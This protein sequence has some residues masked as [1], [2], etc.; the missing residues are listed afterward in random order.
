M[1]RLC[2]VTG[3]NGFIGSNV[4]RVLLE[5][6]YD[7]RALV[8]GDIDQENLSGLPVKIHEIDVLDAASVRAA[9]AG[10][11]HVVHAAAC[12]AFWSQDPQLPYRVNV[13]GTRNV[14]QAARES[15]CEHVV[16]TSTTATLSPPFGG[17]GLTDED[18]V[19]D[20]RRFLGPYKTSKAMA[21]SVAL[22]AAAEGLPVSIVHPTTVLG[23]G[24]R[25]PT[26]T[27]TIVVH[28]LE[29]RMKAYVDMAHNLVDVEDVALGHVLALER[30]SAGRRYILGGENLR[31]RELVRLLAELTGLPAPRVAIPTPLLHAAARANEWLSDHVTRRPPLVPREAILH[32][33]DAR[34]VSVE[35]ARAELGFAPRPAREVLARA[36]RW[37][38]SQGHGDP[39]IAE[40]LG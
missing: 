36:I 1:T 10:A 17:D 37:F 14:L 31:M 34:P 8:G 39:A 12:Y 32:A 4:V 11:S 29:G 6:G 28:F 21:E 3:A 23:A 19:L 22:R 7:V 9:L 15:G 16:Y 25:R 5:R 38:V 13:E 20:L 24:D 18:A 40:R 33:E 35:R 30:G 26:P 2:A 27:G